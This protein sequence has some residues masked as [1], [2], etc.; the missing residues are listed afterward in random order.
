MSHTAKD[1]HDVAA[2]AGS[3]PLVRVPVPPGPRGLDLLLREATAALDGSGPAIAPVPTVGPTISE[4]YVSGVLRAVLGSSFTPT[5]DSPIA[6]VLATSGSTG[7]PRGVELTASALTYAATA[8]HD[9]LRPCWVAALP[10]TSVGGF[11]VMV[12]ALQS[13][14]TPVAVSSLGGAGPFTADAF[15]DAVDAALASGSPVFTSLVPAQLPRLLS[16]ERGTDALRACARVLV[17]GA[18]LRRSLASTCSDLGISVSTTYG[19]TES[20]GGCILDGAPL[21]GVGVEILDPDETG[22]GRIVLTGPTIAARYREDT[23]AT[24]EAFLDGA[25]RTQDLGLWREQPGGPRLTVTGRI[26]DVVIISGVNVSVSAV[27]SVIAD[28]P[29]VEAAAVVVAPREGGEGSLCA[30]MVADASVVDTAAVRA[31]VVERLGAAARPRLLRTID[32]LPYLPNGKIDRVAL[33]QRAREE[34]NGGS[35]N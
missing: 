24:A 27:E 10:L 4:T 20:A 12:R 22:T 13:G 11:N 14:V 2:P 3:R 7:T 19:M 28:Q 25:F 32:R 15:A 16:D 6:V 30:Y 29:H 5:V 17:G 9:G 31:R 18:P 23:A 35:D 21:P 33:Q 26:D 1:G 8:I 34:M